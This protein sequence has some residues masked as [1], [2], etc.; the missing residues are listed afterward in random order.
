[1]LTVNNPHPPIWKIK[2]AG[3]G[4]GDK[5]NPRPGATVQYIHDYVIPPLNE[6]FRHTLH[7]TQK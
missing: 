3:E 6:A 4:V 7:S 5:P 1:M 2:Y